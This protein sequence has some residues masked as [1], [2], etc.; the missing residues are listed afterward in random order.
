M[1]TLVLNDFETLKAQM[2]KEQLWYALYLAI[3]KTQKDLHLSFDEVDD[4]PAQESLF[5]FALGNNLANILE[6]HLFFVP[7]KVEAACASKAADFFRWWTRDKNTLDL[8]RYLNYLDAWN[9]QF[10]NWKE[11]A[12][13]AY[14]NM[15]IVCE[16]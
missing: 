12:P 7:V 4:N 3:G 10:P 6:K 9:E 5:M 2:T 16:D 1:N 8:S 13:L 11:A 14:E 15:I